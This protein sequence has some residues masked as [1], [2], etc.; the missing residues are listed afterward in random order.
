MASYEALLDLFERIQIF[1]QRLNRYTAV[2]LT[3]EFILLLGKIMAQILVVLAF[4]TKEIKERR[5]SMSFCLMFLSVVD[6][7]T[8]KILKRIVGKTDVPDALPRLDMLTKEENLMAVARNLE[9]THR[10]DVNVTATQELTR[11]I[12]DDVKV[13]KLGVQH[14]LDIFIHIVANLC[15]S[16]DK[17][18]MDEQ[19]RSSLPNTLIP[20]VVAKKIRTGDCLRE[21]FRTWL[22]P[23]DPSVNHN[24]ACDTQHEGTGMWF[25]QGNKFN[26]WRKTSSLLWV[27]GNRTF[28][29]LVNLYVTINLF[30]LFF[31]SAGSGKSILWYAA[32]PTIPVRGH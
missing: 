25:I 23:P 13:T 15:L 28:L 16:Y 17:T 22:S 21:K 9:I 27:R 30:P 1:L 8:E 19:Q 12:H 18:A 5:I 7:W 32:F 10:V 14:S 4:S 6:Y 20:I 29:L 11:S 31:F 3:Q 26:E 24:T 2:P